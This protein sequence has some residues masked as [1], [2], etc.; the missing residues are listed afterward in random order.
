MAKIYAMCDEVVGSWPKYKTVC[1]GL[2]VD[3]TRGNPPNIKTLNRWRVETPRGFGFVVHATPE[4][5]KALEQA[6]LKGLDALPASFEEHWN[7]T[8]DRAKAAAAK[9]ILLSPGFDFS[10]GDISRD[11]MA[12]LGKKFEGKQIL[13]WDLEGPWS[14]EGTRSFIEAH[15]M[16][17]AYD[18]F[19]AQRD[20][21][22]FTYGD[23]AFV[24]TERAALRRRF[25]QFDFEDLIDWTARYNRVF[26]LFRGRFKWEH[27][28]EM[29][30]VMQDLELL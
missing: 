3:D 10:P 26:Y 28:K 29:R 24:I 11:L 20:E 1:N 17:Y 5:N 9:A 7:A 4:T 30:Y 2:E 13:I 8:L 18:P 21:I 12:D 6:S 14:L 16:S 27:A 15:G 25:D 22:P 19:L 23:G